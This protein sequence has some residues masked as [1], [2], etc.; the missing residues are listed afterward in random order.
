MFAPPSSRIHAFSNLFK[1]A[2][3]YVLFC[4]DSNDGYYF[5]NDTS[6][7]T[8]QAIVDDRTYLADD[9]STEVFIYSHP[10]EQKDAHVFMDQFAQ[11]H[12]G[13]DPELDGWKRHVVSL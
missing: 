10:Y 3:R 1:V 8:L 11:F 9:D 7:A 4:E 2:Y 5:G 13:E 6:E 12:C